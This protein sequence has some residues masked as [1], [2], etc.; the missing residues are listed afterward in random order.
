M[1]SAGSTQRQWVRAAGCGARSRVTEAGD[2]G[3]TQLGDAFPAGYFANEHGEQAIYTYDYEPGEATIR[4][5]DAGW[6]DAHRIRDGQAEAR[7]LTKTEAMWLRT[8]WLATGALK[9]RST[10]G[11]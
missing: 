1:R 10:H 7:L 2:G 6:H 9:D 5:G 4:M 3:A 11:G 8:C